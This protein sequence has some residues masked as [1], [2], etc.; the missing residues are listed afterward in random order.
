MGGGGGSPE[1]PP[2]TL[3]IPP[4][5]VSPESTKHLTCC[6]CSTIPSLRS[7]LA[8]PRPPPGPSAQ[9]WHLPPARRRALVPSADTGVLWKGVCGRNNRVHGG[10]LFFRTPQ[11]FLSST[12]LLE[13]PFGVFRVNLF[14]NSLATG[15]FSPQN[16]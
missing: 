6:C 8:A 10:G 5:C 3:L 14:L 9:R 12:V 4:S 2:T 11:T 1:G 13:A 16:T 7:A 15:S